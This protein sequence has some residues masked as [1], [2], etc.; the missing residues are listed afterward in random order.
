MHES[1]LIGGRGNGALGAKPPK[2]YVGGWEGMTTLV[3]RGS[4]EEGLS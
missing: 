4:W 3:G 1:W 2:R